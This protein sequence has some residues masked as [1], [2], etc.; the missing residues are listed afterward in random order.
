MSANS[1]FAEDGRQV[2]DHARTEPR[3]RRVRID[4]RDAVSA[5]AVRVRREGGH[6]SVLLRHALGLRLSGKSFAD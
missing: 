5:V 3:P 1:F 4:D 2:D 6:I